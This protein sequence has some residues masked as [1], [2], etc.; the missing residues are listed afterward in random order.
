[1]RNK[2]I[3][4]FFLLFFCSEYKAQSFWFGVKGGGGL[5]FQ[6]WSNSQNN[7]LFTPNGD[8]FIES[9]NEENSGSLYAALGYHTRGSALQAISWNGEFFSNQGFRFRN[10]SLEV[11]LKKPI[12]SP[13]EKAMAYYHFGL[14]AEYN[15]SHNLATYERF[16]NLF[17]P[18]KAFVQKFVY[19]ASL[20]GGFEY[21][22]KDLVGGLVELSLM[23]DLG[24]QY[25][26]PPI[27]NVIDPWTLQKINLQERRI[28]N[29]TFEI[30]VGMRFLRKVIYQ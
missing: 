4:S 12:K 7:A 30:K 9:Y 22:F 28:R 6:N 10:A 8:L 27:N 18:D 23:P 5:G 1:M 13:F 17:Y 19:G 29:L 14:R 11:G 16:G 21:K 20:G 15:L 26:Q 2:I 3:L 24:D 25:F